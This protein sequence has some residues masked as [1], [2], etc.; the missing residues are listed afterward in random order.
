MDGSVSANNASRIG[1]AL[2]KSAYIR[3]KMS[4]LTRWAGRTAQRLAHARASYR[5][6]PDSRPANRGDL[7]L[8]RVETLQ[9]LAATRQDLAATRQELEGI[10]HQLAQLRAWVQSTSD[11]LDEMRGQVDWFSDTTREALDA[12]DHR[13]ARDLPL[14]TMRFEQFTAGEDEAVFGFRDGTGSPRHDLY[15]GFE[16]IFR[17]S[18]RD[19]ANRQ[20]AYLPLLSEHAPVLDVGCGRGE[21]LELLRAAGVEGSGVDLDGGMASHC[22]AKGLSVEAGDGILKLQNARPGSLGA[23]VAAQVVEHLPY[24]HLLAF[25]HAVQAA[26]KPGGITILETVNPHSP[27]AFKHFWVDPSHQHPLFPEV[28][29]Q[30]LRLSG[31]AEGYVWFPLGSGDPVRDHAEQPDYVIVA[32]TAIPDRG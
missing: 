24:A 18:E 30:L 13:V 25:L 2:T 28:M 27:Q 10:T 20:R 12:L 31:F 26:L 5:R 32:T 7:A 23:V 17:G 29:L 4:G 6:G 19:I 21:L 16:D 15:R 22:A 1:H 14:G 9:E 11:S 3:P 8:A